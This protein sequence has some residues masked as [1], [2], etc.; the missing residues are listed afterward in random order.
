MAQSIQNGKISKKYALAT[1]KEWADDDIV[2][3]VK[4]GRYG[5]WSNNGLRPDGENTVGCLVKAAAKRKNEYYFDDNE[6]VQGDKTIMEVKV[7]ITTSKMFYAKLIEL[8]I[9]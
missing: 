6:F 7:G 1:L 8:G 2:M 9:I 3:T 4:M 5:V